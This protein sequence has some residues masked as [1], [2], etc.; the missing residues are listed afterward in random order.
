MLIPVA[1]WRVVEGV[2]SGFGAWTTSS[3]FGRR[4][5]GVVGL[6][7]EGPIIRSIKKV[8]TSVFPEFLGLGHWVRPGRWL[9]DGAVLLPDGMR[10]MPYFVWNHKPSR[11][12]VVTSPGS[13]LMSHVELDVN[14]PKGDGIQQH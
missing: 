2:E 10:A 14:P 8:E 9:Q 1:P 11:D 7:P 12:D 6:K 4:N 5:S 3:T 13:C